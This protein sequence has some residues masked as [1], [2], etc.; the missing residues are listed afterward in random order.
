MLVTVARGVRWSD[1]DILAALQ[2]NAPPG[3]ALTIRTYDLVRAE[4]E[5]SPSLIVERYGT[6]AAALTAAGMPAP[7]RGAWSSWTRT[8]AAEALAI[9]LEHAPDDRYVTFVEA[10][11][12]NPTIPPLH[13][14]VRLFGGWKGARTSARECARPNGS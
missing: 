5:P 4:D 9:W 12:T 10:A 11:R 2:R 7:A 6:W 8:T 14:V 1:N 13:V 3:R